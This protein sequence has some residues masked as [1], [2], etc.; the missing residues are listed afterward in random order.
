MAFHEVLRACLPSPR[1]QDGPS[2]HSGGPARAPRTRAPRLERRSTR[3]TGPFCGV[4]WQVMVVTTS[5]APSTARRPRVFDFQG[6]SKAA[7]TSQ[8]ANANDE[9]ATQADTLRL[10]HRGW[11]ADRRRRG[12]ASAGASA[13]ANHASTASK[14]AEGWPARR[15]GDDTGG[16]P[17]PVRTRTQVPASWS[18]QPPRLL[19]MELPFE[20][21]V[22]MAAY[23][24][25]VRVCPDMVYRMAIF[26][27]GKQCR[28]ASVAPGCM[29]AHASTRMCWRGLP[30][31]SGHLE[32]HAYAYAPCG[33]SWQ[34]TLALQPTNAGD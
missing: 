24:E 29:H 20:V 17:R 31:A 10:P 5:R 18:S 32:L 26:G 4:V 25:P 3:L 21:F 16:E 6:S 30:M 7:A 23:L 8:G 27:G 34:L 11:G 13:T 12:G 22:S 19:R 2:A 28:G 14:D 33:L 1:V 15:P 9:R